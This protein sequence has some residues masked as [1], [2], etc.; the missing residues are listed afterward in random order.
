MCLPLISHLLTLVTIRRKFCSSMLN[1]FILCRRNSKN[2]AVH[3]FATV[4]FKNK[5]ETDL[6]RAPE[7]ENHLGVIRQQRIKSKRLRA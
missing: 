4:R 7:N 3:F 2:I 1:F 5:N 6:P